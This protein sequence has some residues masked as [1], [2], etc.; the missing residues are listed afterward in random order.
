MKIM[1]KKSEISKEDQLEI[2]RIL[3]IIAEETKVSKSGVELMYKTARDILKDETDVN[4]KFGYV[5][6]YT[7]QLVVKNYCEDNKGGL[8]RW[9]KENKQGLDVLVD[10]EVFKLI[11]IMNA[12]TRDKFDFCFYLSYMEANLIREEVEATKEK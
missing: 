8:T 4:K 12:R 5:L 10:D 11:Y 6:A 1:N 3:N 2:D 7:K 9:Y